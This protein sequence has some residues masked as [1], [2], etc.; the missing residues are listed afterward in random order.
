[1]IEKFGGNK[2]WYER[3]TQQHTLSLPDYYIARYP[4]TVAQFKAFVDESGYKPDNENSLR[5][6]D[7]L[8]KLGD[9]RTGVTT[10][11]VFCEIPAGKFLM[12]SNKKDDK[13]AY[14]DEEPQFEYN[15]KHNYF[16]SRYPVTNA[17]FDLFVNDPQ[18]YANERWYTDAGREWRNK[19]KQDRPPKQG[20]AFD[21]PNHPVV[22]VTWYEAVAFTRWLTNKL[23]EEKAGLNVW[24]NDK[25]REVSVDFTRCE[26]RLPSEAEWEKAARGEKG[27]RYPWGNDFNQEKVN[28]NMI[29]GST[30]A[31]G[32]FPAGQS[33][34]GLLDMS[35]NVYEWCATQW[36]KGYKDYNK[37][38]NNNLEGDD[39]RVLRGGAFYDNERYVR[40]AY[41]GNFDPS[42]RTHDFGF[43]V[44]V[45][46][47][48]ST[49]R[50]GGSDSLGL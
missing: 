4:V 13:H 6:I 30:S 39:L 14:D 36:T 46:P 27:L 25:I 41:R 40:C 7:V 20:G 23:R 47:F 2:D 34:Y 38:E 32:C 28:S 15:I 48:F 11:F 16:V 37:N 24:E 19:V 42:G 3:E 49:L 45:S 50:S 29:I 5:G 10:D 1:M 17:Q 21:L 18:G 31:V 43:R 33:P 35:G 22:N 44:V 8:A 26:V 12:G 9:P